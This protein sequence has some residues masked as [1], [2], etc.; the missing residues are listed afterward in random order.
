MKK[1]LFIEAWFPPSAGMKGLRSLKFCKYLP[2]NS[3]EPIVL[4]IKNL[5]N[6]YP[7]DSELLKQISPYI[8]VHRTYAFQPVKI[9]HKLRNL[10]RNRD[11]SS[12]RSYQ[13]K[14]PSTSPKGILGKFKWFFTNYIM[15]VDD[16]I[17]WLPFALI[18]GIRIINRENIDIIFS[19]SGSKTSHLI[20][21]FLKKITR[22]PWI[23]DFRDFWIDHPSYSRT[24]FPKWIEKNIE[25]TVLKNTDMN[26]VVAPSIG[27]AFIRRYNFLSAKHIT[28]ITNGFDLDDYSGSLNRR[29]MNDKFT[30]TYTGTIYPPQSTRS[31]FMA[32]S[33][34]DHDVRGSIRVNIM[35][36]IPSEDQN[37]IYEFN[38]NEVVSVKTF[39]P[40]KESIGCQIKSDV[41]LLLIAPLFRGKGHIT[42]KFFEY[43]GA[44]RPILALVPSEEIVA[45]IVREM[46]IG[47]VVE[48]DDTE[49]I[50]KLILI[51]YNKWKESSLNLRSS[52]FRK[53]KRYERKVLTEKLSEVFNLV[54]EKYAQSYN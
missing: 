35:G 16:D 18:R 30:I 1:V 7:D 27:E 24:S 25:R 11:I 49:I 53:I 36:G 33:D 22:K 23:A 4:S 51:L 29:A 17:G 31:F 10:F 13:I 34:L 40:Y 43:I 21:L 42:G 46:K 2:Q 38:L 12:K 8:N 41:L 39:G 45:N 26:I 6:F 9:F 47:Y 28:I 3:W 48:P 15:I 50:K 14:L 32:L 52:S 5:W 54:F 44:R 20:G 19:T 37:L